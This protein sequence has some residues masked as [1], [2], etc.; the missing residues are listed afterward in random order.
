LWCW[1][2]L[3][4][5]T[6]KDA[7]RGR[8][9]R[10]KVLSDAD[11]TEKYI[12]DEKDLDKIFILGSNKAVIVPEGLISPDKEL[13]V[14]LARLFIQPNLEY[15]EKDTQKELVKVKKN[16]L[17]VLKEVKKGELLVRKNQIIDNLTYLKLQ[18]LSKEITSKG[19][20]KFLGYLSLILVIVMIIIIWG[21]KLYKNLLLPKN[22]ILIGCLIIGILNIAKI[23]QICN[24]SLL[25]LPVATFG[26]IVA[27]LMKESVSIFLSI[28][29]CLLL[30]LL[31]GI[32]REVSLILLLGTLMSIYTIS[33]VRVKTD[34]IKPA[35]VTSLV[36]GITI[37]GFNLI[38]Y[39]RLGDLGLSLFWG[40]G[41]N[42]FFCMVFSWLI[43]HALERLAKI[44]TNFRL[45]E[46][47]DLNLP[48]LKKLLIHAPGTYHHSLL[49]GTLAEAAARVCQANPILTR[50]GAYYHDIG[51]MNRPYYFPEN[52]IGSEVKAKFFQVKTDLLASIYKSHIKDGIVLAKE[53][54][55]P[56]E[57]IDIINQHHG[58]SEVFP[59]YRYKSSVKVSDNNNWDSSEVKEKFDHQVIRYD[60]PKPKIKEAA[61]IMLAD[62]V[63]T[64]SRNL[65]H[66]TTY[67]IENLVKKIIHD[68][69]EERELDECDLTLK[70]L[71]NI[72][73]VFIKT[74]TTLFYSRV[75]PELV[76]GENLS[77]LSQRAQESV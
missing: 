73:F 66:P 59:V 3:R 37:V 72:S 44:T 40:V 36:N 13:A 62:A 41:V 26:I 47:S 31:M 39:Q 60:G 28:I 9:I 50:V 12:K 35:I 74:L 25:G 48:I 54:K 5:E 27:I 49:V 57:I 56:Q 45:F 10:V 58:T 11:V 18:A 70:D 53:N 63:E 20:I 76:E 17:P 38:G 51:K 61:L 29:L 30:D 77:L 52:Q 64:A 21:I 16:I 33:Y 19:R 7:K 55:L 6:K 14:A 46:L 67:R 43:L 32:P 2:Y 34:L 22:L 75:E 65:E 8:G 69:F 4:R 1:F 71:D 68:K 24:F 42:G 15:S 23:M